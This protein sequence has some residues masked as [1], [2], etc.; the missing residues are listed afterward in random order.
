MGIKRNCTAIIEIEVFEPLANI[1]LLE[2]VFKE[3]PDHTAE[4]LLRI[5]FEESEIPVKPNTDTTEST[6]VYCELTPAQTY[7]LTKGIVYMDTRIVR[8][9]GKI[10][11]TEIAVIDDVE[12]SLFGEVHED[13][14]S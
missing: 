14:E 9:D 2:F 3:K 12:E 5:K 13:G 6:V 8:V 11:V 1:K 10:P 4:E 7:K